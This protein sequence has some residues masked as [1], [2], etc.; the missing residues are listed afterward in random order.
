MA[1]V[2]ITENFLLQNDTAVRLVPRVRPADADPRLP[3]PPAPAADRRRPPLRESH[4]DLA[5]RR[6][7][8]VAGD[9]GQR[10]PR[11]L[12]HRR[13]LGLGEVPEM[14]GN[15][16]Q[17]PPQPALPL[18]PPG[19]ETPVRHQRPA[20]RPRH[21][22]RHLGPLQRPARPAGVLL[23]RDHAADERGAGLHHGRPRRRPRAPPGDRRRP[24][25]SRSGCCPRSGR[26]RGWRSSRPRR[27]NAWV[28]RLAAGGGRGYPRFPQL[29]GGH[30]PAARLLPRHGL[31]PLGPRRRDPLRARTTP[32]AKSAPSSATSATA[33][34]H[35][36]DE[37]A[38]FKSA[39]LY[40]FARHGPREGLDAAVPPRG[41]A[42]QQHADVPGRW[43]PTPASTRSAISPWPGRWPGSWTAWTARA[44]SPRRSST[45]STRPT[46][47]CWPR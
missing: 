22:P 30:P 10:R 42:E 2:F 6:P 19:A 45:T 5:L 43:G 41:P 35:D 9:A 14:G 3:L 36:S 31:P 29:P 11:A 47:T 13:R 1:D 37:V 23:P 39:M 44:G 46:T 8:Q 18:D 28:D 7:L 34:A 38:K 32:K 25:V 21:R 20:A 26:T 17:D 24:V 33:A 16:P 27:F 12:L 4:A 15:R 40:E